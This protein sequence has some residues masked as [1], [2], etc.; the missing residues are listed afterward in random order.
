MKR[1]LYFFPNDNV[2]LFQKKK[3]NRFNCYV[4]VVWIESN[5]YPQ[6][7]LETNEKFILENSIEIMENFL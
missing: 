4:W 6:F 1:I 7:I 2:N 5:S 3:K